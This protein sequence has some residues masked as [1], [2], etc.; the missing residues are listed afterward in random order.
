MPAEAR[1]LLQRALELEP[2]HP[3]AL[4]NLALTDMMQ[5]QP[6]PAIAGFER[7]LALV[8]GG[9]VQASAELQSKSLNNLGVL[10]YN[11]ASTR[12]PRGVCSG[13]SS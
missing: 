10:Y 7:L 2:T 11:K 3:D 12:T 1:Q 13:R 6:E 9:G 4:Y 5:N 8:A